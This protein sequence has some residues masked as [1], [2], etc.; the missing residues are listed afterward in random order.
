MLLAS[1]AKQTHTLAVLPLYESCAT[2]LPQYEAKLRAAGYRVTFR[3]VRFTTAPTAQ[4]GLIGY[5]DIDGSLSERELQEVQN[6]LKVA[7]MPQDSVRMAISD[8]SLRHLPEIL[9]QQ[10]TSTEQ[11]LVIDHNTITIYQNNSTKAQ[12]DAVI[13]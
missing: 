10:R 11:Y 5:L 12:R 6:G 3:P 9:R 4:P 8:A 2:I 7:C 13:K 1:C